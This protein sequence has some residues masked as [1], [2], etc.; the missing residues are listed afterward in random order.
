MYSWGNKLSENAEKYNVRDFFKT[1]I[2]LTNSVALSGGTEKNQTYFSA[3]ST[4]AE[5]IVP[6]NKYN[7][8]NFTIRNSSQ[9]WK[10]RLRIDA[11]ANYISQNNLNMINQGE[12]M[13][14]LVSAY[15][16]PRGYGLQNAKNFERYNATTHI[17][18]QVWG[19]FAAGPDGTFTGN[20]TG[21][22]SMQNPYWIAYRNLREVKRDRYLLSLGATLDLIKWNKAEK[23]DITARMRTDNTHIT[24]TDKRYASTLATIVEAKQVTLALQEV[25]KSKLTLMCLPI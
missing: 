19:D 7:R 12:Y 11:S 13:N 9:L 3:A 15:L 16:M 20:F 5:G 21:D 18:E 4:N 10:D 22:H 2:T 17:Y 25:M 8:Y 14:P 6:N 24:N 23:W 1:A